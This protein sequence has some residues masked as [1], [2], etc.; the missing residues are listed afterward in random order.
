VVPPD[1][2]ATGQEKRERAHEP[3]G[4]GLP[5]PDHVHAPCAGQHQHNR[6]RRDEAL[7][8]D[9][10][11]GDPDG[12]GADGERANHGGAEQDA[13]CHGVE[14]FAQVGH[15]PEPASELTV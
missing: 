2:R 3:E 4:A 7:A 11:C 9:G 10:R 8:G 15:L 5:E 13:V 14:H 1:G 6:H 12:H